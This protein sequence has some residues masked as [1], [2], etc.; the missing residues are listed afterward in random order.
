[1]SAQSDPT[2]TNA[3]PIAR[4]FTKDMGPPDFIAIAVPVVPLRPRRAEPCHSL[5]FKAPRDL[6]HGGVFHFTPGAIAKNRGP[7]YECAGR[8]V[9]AR[10][11]RVRIRAGAN[12]R[13]GTH[14]QRLRPIGPV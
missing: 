5:M 13:K 7:T 11:P 2:D 6:S 4:F 3:S 1:M 9:A 12:V 8:P 14:V 10:A